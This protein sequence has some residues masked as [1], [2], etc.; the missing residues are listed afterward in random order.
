MTDQTLQR[1]DEGR[2]RWLLRRGMKEL[3]I[4]MERYYAQ[5]FGD[6]PDDEKAQFVKLLNQAEDPDIWAWIMDYEPVPAAMQA[7]I[8]QLRVYR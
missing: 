4:I 5:R 3:D 7:L 1:N 6:A 2:L 8:E